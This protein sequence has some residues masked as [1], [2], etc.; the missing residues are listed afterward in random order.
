MRRYIVF[1]VLLLYCLVFSHAQTPASPRSAKL[2]TDVLIFS[3]GDQLTGKLERVEAGKVIFSSEMAGELTIPID[4]VKE[5]RSGAE[6]ALLRKGEPVGKAQADVGSVDLAHGNL[7]FTPPGNAPATV[8]AGEVAYL[9]DKATFDKEVR[10]KAGFLDG[11][12]GTITGGANIERSTTSGTTLNA[13]LA[14]VRT[15]PIV[16]WMPARNRTSVNVMESYGKLSTAVIPPTSP[17][18]PATVVVSSIFHADVERDQYFRPRLFVLADTAFDHNYGQGLQFQQ[19]YGGGIG[20]TALKSD[21]QELDLKVD[22]HFERQQYISTPANGSATTMTSPVNIIGST[23]FE[24]YHRDL[25]GKMV[26]TETANI[27]PAWNN[28]ESYSAN[29]TAALSLPLFKRLSATVTTTDNYLN[30]PAKYYQKNSYQFI[31]G[32]TYLL[33]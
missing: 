11:W 24:E 31:T 2:A 1:A 8:P 13:S 23:L 32:V 10:R 29:V 12:N 9:V 6:F 5:L 20:W 21:K 33:R 17:S 22:V 26:F 28:F 30:D 15:I 19:I 16:P 4:K 18:A 27:L 3:N 14:L 7:T 25:P